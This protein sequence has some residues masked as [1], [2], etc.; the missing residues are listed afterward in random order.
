VLFAEQEDYK[1]YGDWIIPYRAHWEVQA[2]YLTPLGSLRAGMAGVED[3]R[4]FYYV[5]FGTGFELG[6]DLDD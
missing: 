3:G 4:P 6:F 5:H 1:T 2:G